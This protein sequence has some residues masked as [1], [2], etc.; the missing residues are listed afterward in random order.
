MSSSAPEIDHRAK[1]VRFSDDELTVVLVDGRSISVPL[2][3]FPR[4]Q[5]ATA[6]ERRHFE[7]I[8]DG[9]GIH[10]PVIDEDL[11]VCIWKL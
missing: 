1:E 9:N 8:G 6:A 7:L 2:A 10:W 5:G 3:W 4:L 11:S